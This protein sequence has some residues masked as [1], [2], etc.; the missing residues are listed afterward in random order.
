MM[1]ATSLTHDT[2]RRNFLTTTAALLQVKLEVTRLVFAGFAVE[3]RD[4]I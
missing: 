1:T 2:E 3:E 4:Q